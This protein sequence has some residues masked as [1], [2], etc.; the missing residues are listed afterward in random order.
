[1]NHYIAA[2]AGTVAKSSLSLFS[3]AILDMEAVSL[4]GKAA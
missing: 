3:K 1:M 2:L 4:A